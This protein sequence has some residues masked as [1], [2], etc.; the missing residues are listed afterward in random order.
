MELNDGRDGEQSP[1]G[2]PPSFKTNV[3][4]QKTKRWVNAKSYSYDGDDWGDSDEYE[5]EEPAAR[6]ATV[7]DEAEEASPINTQ[8]NQQK[9]QGEIPAQRSTDHSESSKPLPFIR[10]ADIYKRM[11]QERQKQNRKEVDQ[12]TTHDTPGAAQ[13]AMTADSALKVHVPSESPLVQ[14]DPDQTSGLP[15]NTSE[16]QPKFS[17]ERKSVSLALAGKKPVPGLGDGTMG[18]ASSLQG[19][20]SNK[21][22]EEK[23]EQQPPAD[24][25]ELQHNPSLGF[26]SVVHQAFDAPPETPSTT[27]S[28]ILRSDS[29]S[30]SIISPIIQSHPSSAFGDGRGAGASSDQ[31]PTI[32]EEPADFKPGHRRSLSPPHSGSTTARKPIVQCTVH[33]AKSQLGGVSGTGT[34]EAKPTD[35]QGGEG[36]ILSSPTVSD[37]DTPK[38]AAVQS[39]IPES[40]PT[41]PETN[42]QPPSPASPHVLEPPTEAPPPAALKDE[43]PHMPPALNVGG[44]DKRLSQIQYG[45]SAPENISPCSPENGSPGV[46]DRLRDEIMQS[47]TPRASIVSH[48]QE[49]E[50]GPDQSLPQPLDTSSHPQLP[51]HFPEVETTP[52]APVFPGPGPDHSSGLAGLQ[53]PAT[54][55]KKRFSWEESSVEDN[56]NQEPQQLTI[57]PALAADAARSSLE[58]KT[59]TAP[60]RVSQDLNE[61]QPERSP[62]TN[63]SQDVAVPNPATGTE[64]NLTQNPTEHETPSAQ[65]YDNPPIQPAPV[66]GSPSTT[67]Q[68]QPQPQPQPA[69]QLL[70]TQ[71]PKLLGFRQIMAMEKSNEKIETF[72][73]T[74]KQF[75]NMDTGLSSW[76][77]ATTSSHPDHAELAQRNGCLPPGT[78]FAHKP[79][80]SRNKF[81]KLGSL[82]SLSLQTSH[83]EGSPTTATTTT[84]TGHTR[85][86]STA[87]QLTTKINT[88]QVQA[89]GKDLLHSAGVLGGKAGGAA[90]GLFAKGRSKFRNSSSTDKVDT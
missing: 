31:T 25:T 55:L 59:P 7:P 54:K 82:G 73:R 81:P 69:P 84:T 72:E 50:A 21:P 4:R 86:P 46:H 6:L 15:I 30:T 29:A 32:D 76:I 60:E 37:L 19:Q 42:T 68:P 23:Q 52:I 14:Q 57:N 36:H 58:D 45:P 24:D 27:T 66:E 22:N 90:K 1:A 13:A 3:S 53:E 5:D 20:D 51:P 40:A 89:K 56:N 88:Q 44:G 18:G 39:S 64:V 62:D 34:P 35:A 78:T 9:K 49:Q 74:R 70:A 79:N 47:L 75:A 43:N 87:T 61:Q 28:S 77:E 65:L 17:A 41:V 85:H 16:N 38:Q 63:F 8:E 83:H 12:S 48:G 67:V 71:D 80:P 10:P 11:E 26:R 2:Q 33:P